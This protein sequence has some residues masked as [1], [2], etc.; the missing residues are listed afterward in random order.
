MKNPLILVVLSLFTLCACKKEKVKRPYVPIV[1]C[2]DMTKNID[3]INMF[4]QGNWEW[5]E[6]YRVTRYNG[7]EYFTPSSPNSYHLNLKLS[8]DTARFFVNSTPDSIY[9][10]RIQRELEITN[11]PTDSLPVIVYYSF[12]TGQRMSYVPIMICKNQL[13]MQ[14]QYVSSFVGERLWIRK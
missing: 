7:E 12:Y 13:L 3:T 2:A 8:G 5:V 4:I 1:R 6:E 9:R 14:H 11:Y 10:F